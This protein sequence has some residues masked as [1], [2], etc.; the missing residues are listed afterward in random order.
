LRI[1]RNIENSSKADNKKSLNISGDTL[2][3]TCGNNASQGN[4]HIKIINS[5]ETV[6]HKLPDNILFLFPFTYGC[7]RKYLLK[8][9]DV[10]EKS[11]LNYRI[12][13]DYLGDYKI[14]QLR[15]ASDIFIYLPISDQLSGSMQEC[16]YAGNIVLTGDWLPYRILEEQGI[17]MLKISSVDEVG[18]KLIYLLNHL[19]K[20]K[21]SCK[22]NSQIIWNLSSW[23]KNIDNWIQMYIELLQS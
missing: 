8:V 13:T 15:K 11:N 23:D 5:I 3:V 2:V 17:F 12:L 20:L 16:L 19:K 9:K 4:Q 1:L 7:V 18:E 10:L 21:K 22:G 14:A 6:I